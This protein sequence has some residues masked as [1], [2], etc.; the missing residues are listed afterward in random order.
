[1]LTKNGREAVVFLLDSAD[2]NLAFNKDGHAIQ[3][4]RNPNHLKLRADE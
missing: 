2:I 1:V 3:A 4:E